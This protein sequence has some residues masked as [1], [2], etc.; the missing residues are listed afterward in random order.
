MEAEDIKTGNITPD[1]HVEC[2]IS[3]CA[4]CRENF[5][6]VG[7]AKYQR[8]MTIG[9]RVS[10]EKKKVLR[11]HGGGPAMHRRVP[12]SGQSPAMGIHKQIILK[13]S[14]RNPESL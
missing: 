11:R 14:G 2:G 1:C 10:C 6:L 13:D 8:R 9:S 3:L 4:R 5:N 12:K 7:R